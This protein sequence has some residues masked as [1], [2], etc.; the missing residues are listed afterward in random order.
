MQGAELCARTWLRASAS[1]PASSLICTMALR[2][3]AASSLSA[4]TRAGSSKMPHGT[5]QCERTAPSAERRDAGRIAAAR[6]ETMR[7]IMVL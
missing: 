3:V 5:W 2:T 6:V 7:S 1:P 4:S